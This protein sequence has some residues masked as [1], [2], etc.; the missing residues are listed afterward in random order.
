M[1]GKK[2][3]MPPHAAAAAAAAAVVVVSITPSSIQAQHCM[4]FLIYSDFCMA[5]TPRTTKCREL[6]NQQQI[7]SMG[8]PS[9]FHPFRCSGVFAQGVLAPFE[10]ERSQCSRVHVAL[11]TLASHSLETRTMPAQKKTFHM[12]GKNHQTTNKWHSRKQRT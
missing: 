7:W 10:T 5:L 1:G 9:I 8:D 2:A 11:F 12:R 6:D 3:L 4:D